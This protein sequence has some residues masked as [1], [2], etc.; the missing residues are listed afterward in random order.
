[1]DISQ[2][3]LS[4]VVVHMKY[5][6]YLP[7]KQRRETWDELVDRNM[8]MH[9]TKFPQLKDEI[10]SVYNNYVRTK[11]I[12]PSMRSLQFAGKPIDLTPSRLFN[13]AYTPIDDWRAFGE[14]MFLLLGGTGVGYSV[15]RHDIEKLPE[16][17]KPN[18][19]RTRR[20]L[21]GDSIE[22]WADCI[23]MLIKNYTTGGPKIV[24]DFQDIRPKG[25]RLIT[26]GGKAPGP[27]PL[28]D[29]V[30]KIEGIL[31]S[32]QDGDK[33][34]SIEVHDIVCHI[35][36]SVLAGGIRRCLPHGSLVHTSRGLVKMCEINIG[37]EVL[38]K[39]GGFDKVVDME[40]T[41]EKEL[42]H[43]ITELGVFKSSKDHRWAVLDTL[44][45][46]VIFK[47][48]Q[49]LT[50]NDT[51]MMIPIGIDGIHTE[52]PEF[53]FKKKDADHSSIDIKIPKLDTDIA[54]L[55]GLIH[56]DG[57]IQS[58]GRRK[59]VTIAFHVDQV[60]EVQKAKTTLERFG[61][62]TRVEYRTNERCTR[63]ICTSRQLNEY[64]SQFKKSKESIKIPPCILH[65]T[66]DIRLAY[67]AGVIDSD[68]SCSSTKVGRKPMRV[69]SSIYEDY[70]RQIRALIFSLGYPSKYNMRDR[71]HAGWKSIGAVDVVGTE[72]KDKFANDIKQYSFKV[73]RDF[74]FEPFKAVCGGLVVPKKQLR[75]SSIS[76]PNKRTYAGN[77]KT[78][79]SWYT[80]E[81]EF[82]TRS[83]SPVRI[84]RVIVESGEITET[85]DIQVENSEMFVCEGML[86][87]NSA[88]IS[89]FNADDD[90]ML[91]C[92]SGNWWE[93]NPQRGRANNSAVLVRHKLTKDVFL[94]IWDRLKNSGSGEPGIFLTNNDMWGT[95][96]SMA[97]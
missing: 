84:D 43:I 57:H 46:D 88:L 29:C 32:K 20:W 6:R 11:K 81:N 74:N 69:L 62:N 92:K 15:Q 10:E 77:N 9:I 80:F 55:I 58:T 56:G 91:S 67:L 96:P 19:N 3:I 78:Y 75:E 76:M 59:A 85:Y 42:T 83:Y 90:E 45:G 22:G 68:G 41:G 93:L 16:I 86:V 25:T 39:D 23:K 61:V 63:L 1:M 66:K 44:E 2:K 21:V 64:L 13:C 48:A 7:D 37:D 50:S 34:T 47:E 38:N 73:R 14:V 87:H 49:Y 12:L 28:K 72:N 52:L 30:L 95:N 82:G 54:W 4:D 17:R 18:P 79:K 53:D 51:L 26:A 65:G 35:A 5:A 31:D 36:D 27:R 97:A 24:F 71:K 33:L 40:Y 60:S 94:S 8:A 89:L 70:L